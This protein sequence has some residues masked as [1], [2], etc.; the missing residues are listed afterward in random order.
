MSE[1]TQPEAPALANFATKRKT[2]TTNGVSEE[3]I[4][5]RFGAAPGDPAMPAH[6]VEIR[7]INAGDYFDLAEAGGEAVQNP[8]WLNLAAVAM[9]VCSIDGVPVVSKALSKAALRDILVK[10]GADGIRAVRDASEAF[11]GTHTDA[12]KAA[13]GNF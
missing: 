8:V 9:S 10:L 7:Q 13:A 12:V 1:T 6:V 3:W 5:L 4:E 11:D 2:V